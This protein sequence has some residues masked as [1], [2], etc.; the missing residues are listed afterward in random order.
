MT[1]FIDLRKMIIIAVGLLYFWIGNVFANDNNMQRQPELSYKIWY[2]KFA[3]GTC[4]EY[5]ASRRKD[6]FPSRDWKDRSFWGNAISWLSQAKKTW[7]PT[8]KIAQVWAIAVYWKWR[9]ASSAYWHVAI[10]EKI[11]DSKTIVV[12]DMNYAW[13]NKVTKRTISS[14]LALGYIY[15]IPDT[16]DNENQMKKIIPIQLEVW[17]IE[18]NIEAWTISEWNVIQQSIIPTQTK[19]YTNKQSQWEIPKNNSQLSLRDMYIVADN[20]YIMKYLSHQINN[21]TVLLSENNYYI[22]V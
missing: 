13:Y 11:I 21:W 14:N 18:N 7:I 16:T 5:A 15:K 4:T 2:A 10:V 8:G 20:R 17:K 3:K 12:S 22:T 6:L 19:I 9:W 1:C